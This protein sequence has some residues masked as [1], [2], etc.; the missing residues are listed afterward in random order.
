M[1]QKEVFAAMKIAI[2]DDN[3]QDA[4]ELAAMIKAHP[5][6]C[7][8]IDTYCSAEEILDAYKH[9]TRYDM[10]FLDIQMGG[11]DGY[12]A[13]EHLF[14]NYRNEMPLTVFVTV[15]D[16]YVFAGYDVRAF[17][18]LPKPVDKKRLYEKLDQANG[19][20]ERGTMTI[21][22]DG[23]NVIIPIKDIL[24]IEADNNNVVI[25]T[26]TKTF[27]LRKPI[28]EMLSILPTRNFVQTHRCCI[29]NLEHVRR[30]DNKYVYFDDTRKADISRQKK[31][32]FLHAIKEYLRS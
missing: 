7:D 27:P 22:V 28:N 23:G 29:V 17:G 21:R 25:N 6:C 18:Y 16:K 8:D 30:Y 13:A 15:T 31:K 12:T 24:F 3:A 5:L 19:E 10:V 1:K 14:K 9:G 20:L 11:I 32:E 2:C 26:V 4:A